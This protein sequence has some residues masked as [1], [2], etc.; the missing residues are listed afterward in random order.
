MTFDDFEMLIKKICSKLKY[1]NV[2]IRSDNIVY[3]DA[4]RWKKFISEYLLQL[5]EFYFDYYTEF[6]DGYRPS[7][8]IG[9]SNQFSSSFWLEK[10]WIFISQIHMYEIIYSIRPY[11]YVLKTKHTFIIVF[12]LYRKK[13]YEYE[14]GQIDNSSIQRSQSAQLEL[15]FIFSGAEMKFLISCIKLVLKV[16]DIYHLD[17]SY[18]KICIDALIEIIYVLPK[19]ISL[20][21]RSL[22]F[23]QSL[24]LSDKQIE[25]FLL[26]SNNNQITKVYLQ[27]MNHI[28][29]IYFLM[30]IFPRI[31]SIHFNSINNINVE[32][33][34]RDILLKINED[35]NQYLRLL[36]LRVP[37]V[38]DQMI[39][40]LEI[41]IHLNK[42]IVDY[43][44]KRVM[45]HIYLQ[46]K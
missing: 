34:I 7:K 3:L 18:R 22:S 46:W 6:G 13:W 9:Q 27:K 16:E 25:R 29:E 41:M 42:L 36:C 37:T 26:I 11:T 8:Y 14:H 39:K 31:N 17:I 24:N 45:D 40:K 10:Q 28:D 33:F 30:Q 23:P 21:I 35:S 43:Q 4:I 44:I 2:T 32:L 19:L 12:F 15:T 1:L 5:K 20:K 38:D